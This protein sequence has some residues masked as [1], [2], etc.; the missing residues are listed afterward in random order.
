LTGFIQAGPQAGEAVEVEINSRVLEL[1]VAVK[2]K[3]F[4]TQVI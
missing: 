1:L 3:D 2:V 4:P